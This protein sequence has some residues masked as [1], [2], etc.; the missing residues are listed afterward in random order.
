MCTEKGWTIQLAK[1]KLRERFVQEN[2]RQSSLDG[3]VVASKCLHFIY[4]G[5]LLIDLQMRLSD[6]PFLSRH[7][8]D[9]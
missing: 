5:S 2:M 8:S 7:S 4:I 6:L 3:I 1:R 9:T